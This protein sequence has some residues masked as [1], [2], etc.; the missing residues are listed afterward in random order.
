MTPGLLSVGASHVP[1]VSG[2]HRAMWLGAAGGSSDEVLW[3][4]G[5]PS[6]VGWAELA[7]AVATTAPLG[8]VALQYVGTLDVTAEMGQVADGVSVRSTIPIATFNGEVP[9]GD[10]YL[11]V[12]AW[13]GGGGSGPA[14]WGS[15]W[16]D[17]LGSGLVCTLGGDY[18]LTRPSVLMA[19]GTA[20]VFEARAVRPVSAV[21]TMS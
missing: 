15:S 10:L 6:P 3:R 12:A 19:A 2:E 14:L 7:L 1:L 13:W 16:T 8:N 9:V 17:P 18:G 21:V 4:M 20:P 5:M 11:V